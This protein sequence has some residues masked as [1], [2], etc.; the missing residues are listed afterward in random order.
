MIKKCYYIIYM[1]QGLNYKEMVIQIVLMTK[2][3]L[4]DKKIKI[5][6]FSFL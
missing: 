1:N 4:D 6:Y 5:I 3:F 2:Y